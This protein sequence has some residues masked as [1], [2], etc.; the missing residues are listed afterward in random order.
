MSHKVKAYYSGK[1]NTCKYQCIKF[2]SYLRANVA[3]CAKPDDRNG[4]YY[5]KCWEE[6]KEE[7][8]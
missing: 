6:R 3:G 8:E 7:L 4:F 5:P 2:V 1:C